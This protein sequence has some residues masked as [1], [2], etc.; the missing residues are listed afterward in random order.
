MRSW[1]EPLSPMQLVLRRGMKTLDTVLSMFHSRFS[2]SEALTRPAMISLWK[3]SS[4][5]VRFVL[6]RRKYMQNPVSDT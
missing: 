1:L 3:V 4:P 2:L 5:K 6:V